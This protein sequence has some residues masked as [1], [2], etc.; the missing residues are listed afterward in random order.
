V[1]ASLAIEADE[2]ATRSIFAGEV[3]RRIVKHAVTVGR[4]VLHRYRTG[5]DHGLH[6]TVVEEIARELYGDLIGSIIWG[7]M[8][9]DASDHFDG[10]GF[11]AELVQA[12]AA[13]PNARVKVVAHSAGAIFASEM[14]IWVGKH[15]RRLS[16]DLV[17]LAAAVRTSKFAKALELSERC[18]LR[19]RSFFMRDEWERKNV[20]LGQGFGFIYPSSLL[21]LVSGLF[22]EQATE[23]WPTRR[24]S[25][26]RGFSRRTAAGWTMR[27][28]GRRLRG[29]R[30]TW[31]PSLTGWCS[32]R[33]AAAAA[34]TVDAISHGDFDNE[35]ATLASVAHF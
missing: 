21:Y 15:D 7:M 26:W 11:G 22:E 18:I 17:F 13:N 12:L 32:R 25:A 10:G 3:V 4:R 19:F 29:C 8:K 27:A 2:A 35:A 23:D 34:S 20:L 9:G 31:R 24:W 30:P 1:R 28:K 16:V 6:A 33:L 5:R 14:L